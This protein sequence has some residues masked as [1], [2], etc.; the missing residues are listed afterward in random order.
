MRPSK[1]TSEERIDEALNALKTVKKVLERKSDLQRGIVKLQSELQQLDV[2]ESEKRVELNELRGLTDQEFQRLS[3]LRS[4]VSALSDEIKIANE[5]LR[6][7]ISIDGAPLFDELMRIAEKTQAAEDKKVESIIVSLEDG[8]RI[9]ISRK[10]YPA[11][12]RGGIFSVE[13]AAAL[14]PGYAIIIMRAFNQTHMKMIK[15]A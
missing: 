12:F 15:P 14:K 8:E 11:V 3:Q 6:K 13:S 7:T 2:R 5:T 9:G 1:K 4:N 10:R